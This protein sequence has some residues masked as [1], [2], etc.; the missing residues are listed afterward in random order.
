ML[1]NKK[2]S[3]KQIIEAI[4]DGKTHSKVFEYLYLNCFPKIKALILKGGGGLEEARDIFQ[5]GVFTFYK[6][7]K[8]NKYKHYTEID[9]YIYTICRN[10]W[11]K[12]V[13]HKNKITDL[14]ESKEDNYTDYSSPETAFFSSERQEWVMDLLNQVGSRC[15]ELM[16]KKVYYNLSISEICDELG[17]STKEA[18][19][20]KV[21]KC[22]QR[23]IGLL[24]Y[25]K[26]IKEIYY[27]D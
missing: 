22:K 18:A 21:Y 25:N 14:P 6:M 8:L 17:F 15:K 9:A 19:K 16:I 7:V 11:Y 4:K 12:R 20:T 10:E 5:D 27:N 3:E 23:L 13:K 2:L 1:K 26:H 24:K